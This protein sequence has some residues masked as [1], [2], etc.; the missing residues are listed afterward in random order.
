MW[1]TNEPTQTQPYGRRIS[2]GG[3]G[4]GVPPLPHRNHVQT[5]QAKLYFKHDYADEIGMT[6]RTFTEVLH[7]HFRDNFLI[8]ETLPGDQVAYNKEIVLHFEVVPS[9]LA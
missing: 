1:L 4:Y 5:Y 3:S 6:E 8:F 2:V 7:F 9:K